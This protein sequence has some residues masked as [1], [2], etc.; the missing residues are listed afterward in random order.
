MSSI[1]YI[2]SDIPDTIKSLVEI[3]RSCNE[4]NSEN[5]LVFCNN[6]QCSSC[7][8]RFIYDIAVL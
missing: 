1:Y 7:F 3:E 5:M 4:E 6:Y 8:D 2:M